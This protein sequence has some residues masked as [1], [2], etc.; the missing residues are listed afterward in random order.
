MFN[1]KVFTES[2]LKLFLLL[3]ALTVLIRI[4]TLALSDVELDES[5]YFLMAKSMVQGHAPYSAIWDHKPPGIYAIFYSAFTLFGVSTFSMRL[6][7]C[8]A[9]ALSALLTAQIYRRLRPAE[10]WYKL[11][12]ALL[13]VVL[14][15]K[16][17][18]EGSNTEV[19]F[20]PV[21]AAAILWLLLGIDETAPLR[22]RR[23]ALLGAGAAAGAAFWIKLNTIV[24][25]GLAGA[26][27]VLWLAGPVRPR[28]KRI[29]EE[30]AL[31]AL[32]FVL[33]GLLA[34][35]P[36]WLT[37]HLTLL[38]TSVIDANIRHAGQRMG[39]QET[40]RYV[41]LIFESSIL[42]WTL[43]VCG[44]VLR[45]GTAFDQ[46]LD[47]AFWFVLAW[48]AG[49]FI[50]AMAP[51]QPYL[52]YALET[53]VPLSVLATLCFEELFLTYLPRSRV[54]IAA[55]AFLVLGSAGTQP[56]VVGL[57]VGR[58]L[59]DYVKNRSLH[60]VDTSRAVG[61]Y[62]QEQA[63][64][65]PPTLFVLDGHPIIYHTSG[66]VPP[67]KYAFPPFLLDPHFEHVT[68][69]DGKTEIARIV[70]DKPEFIVRRTDPL[71]VSV[72]TLTQVNA[73]LATR[74]HI[75]RQIHNVEI[76]RRND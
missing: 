58:E 43:V 47:R 22:T 64:S 26:A 40:F 60:N 45:L 29:G 71:P 57:N 36:F 13:V 59:S 5:V 41:M 14:F 2:K 37:D 6:V 3:L 28:L 34:L 61:D 19:F 15:R 76:L 39:A 52:H 27:A 72:E 8:L 53:V 67:T 20:T 7:A 74:Y 11:L 73:E 50:S 31:T 10:G 51:G 21:V 54:L 30:T 56:L 17:G 62:I 23:L 48:L 1:S 16:S 63:S 33:F 68:G 42:L 49:A 9:V 44:L 32:G 12:P 75:D 70:A 4:D 46:R 25:V 38:K 55:A 18:G 24:E 65:S 69:V 66:V 35:L